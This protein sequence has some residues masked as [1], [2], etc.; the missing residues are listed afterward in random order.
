M[1]SYE[2]Y[3]NPENYQDIIKKINNLPTLG[4]IHDYVKKIYP[5]WIITFLSSYCDDYPHLYKNW[6]GLTKHLNI[7]PTQILIVEDFVPND[8][9]SLINYICECFTRA[10][11]SVRR[12]TEFHP[13]S[14]CKKAVPSEYMWKIF[15]EN[16]IIVPEPWSEKCSNCT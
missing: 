9:H 3:K 6:L 13:C 7:K 10:G 8:T 15:K 2:K 12:K 14:S 11:F 1:I 4:H 5:D 16:G